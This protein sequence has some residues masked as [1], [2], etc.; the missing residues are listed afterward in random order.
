MCRDF[1][2]SEYW[3]DVDMDLQSVAKLMMISSPVYRN[4]K[5]FLG[6]RGEVNLLT[7]RQS[8]RVCVRGGIIL[9]DRV[10]RLPV[11]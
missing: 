8:P 1:F 3:N 7:F 6:T 5:N 2:L 9:I 11:V 4:R 10:R